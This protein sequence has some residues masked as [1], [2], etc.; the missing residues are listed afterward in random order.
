MC[1]IRERDHRRLNPHRIVRGRRKKP[2]RIE[3]SSTREAR[4]YLL[5]YTIVACRIH[6]N[7]AKRVFSCY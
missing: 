1:H 6:Q 5:H 2:A 3:L 4:G 7:L